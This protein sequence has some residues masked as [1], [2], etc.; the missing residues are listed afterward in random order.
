M[1]WLDQESAGNYETLR[2]LNAEPTAT[3]VL[4]FPDAIRLYTDVRVTQAGVPI[5]TLAFEGSDEQ[6]LERLQQGGFS[7][8]LI[9]RSTWRGEK[10]SWD[11]VSVINE[12]FLRCNTVLVGGT[13]NNYLYRLLPPEQRGCKQD[14]ASGPELLQQGRFMWNETDR[15][16]NRM[17][18][19]D[20]PQRD[21]MDK[22]SGTDD[23]AVLLKN[24]SALSVTVPISPDTQYLLSSATHGVADYGKAQF[25]IE[26]YDENDRV[27]ST[28]SESIPASPV[29]YHI[30]STLAVAPPHATKAIVHV[31]ALNATIWFKDLSLR[32][33]GSASR[34]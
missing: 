21:P 14:W 7:H 24:D 30:F 5:P 34:R 11:K 28:Y 3:R 32:T 20:T 29:K 22:P 18:I 13:K 6:V 16:E 9:E 1:D 17:L 2:L 23:S 8:I 4:A 33:F 26:W 31:K 12:D 10:R 15:L 19:G 25:T 27:L